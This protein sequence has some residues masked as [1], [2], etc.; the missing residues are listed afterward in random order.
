MCA[1]NQFIGRI[2]NREQTPWGEVEGRCDLSALVAVCVCV[3]WWWWGGIFVCHCSKYQHIH[4]MPPSGAAGSVR[5]T[6]LTHDS[7]CFFAAVVFQL[8]R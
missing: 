6:S 1:D 4:H 8:S 2:V 3:L 5:V 7:S